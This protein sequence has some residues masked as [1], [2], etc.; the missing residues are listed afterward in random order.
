MIS[1]SPPKLRS[2]RRLGSFL[3]PYRGRFAIAGAALLVA[4]GCTLA[5][6]QGLKLVVDRGFLAN[7]AGA[8]DQALVG[9]LA[10]IA[11]RSVAT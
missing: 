8:L 2:F 6:G 4:A 1:A 10:I 5:V 7:D 3:L 9:L 11:A